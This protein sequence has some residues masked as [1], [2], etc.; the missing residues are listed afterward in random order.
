MK[1]GFI[2]RKLFLLFLSSTLVSNGLDHQTR[3]WNIISDY[4]TS[5]Q[6][7][8]LQKNFPVSIPADEVTVQLGT[9]LCPQEKQF[10]ENRLK[11]VREN[12]KKYFDI[13]QPLS[14]GFCCSGGGNRA[15]IGTLGLLSG[16]IQTNLLDVTMYL[17]GVSGSTWAIVPYFYQL[18]VLSKD[19]QT[20]CDDLYTYFLNQLSEGTRL[21]IDYCSPALLNYYEN[22]D[23]LKDLVMRYGYSQDV[24]LV[25]LWGALIGHQSL[26]FLGEN[27][28][29]QCWSMMVDQ[30]LQANA[31]LPL[32]T[33]AFRNYT[34]YAFFETSPF[35]AGSKLLGYIP[36][37]YLGSNFIN[38]K[39][40]LEGICPE[41]TLAFFLG[42]YGSSFASVVQDL[43]QME[44]SNFKQVNPL[45][46]LY[47]KSNLEKSNTYKN[48]SLFNNWNLFNIFSIKNKIKSI[49][50][51]VLQDYNFDLYAT[52]PNYNPE[53]LS[54]NEYLGLFDAGIGCN[55]PISAFTDRP[56]RFLDIMIMYDS[57]PGSADVKT[58]YEYAVNCGVAMDIQMQNLSIDDLSKE[59]MHVFNDPRSENYN[60]SSVTILYFPTQ[61]ID[62]SIPPYST[63]NFKYEINEIE[64]LK[65]LME[66]SLISNIENIRTI[67]K[68]IANKKYKGE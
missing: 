32:C 31:P 56:E 60:A 50:E 11:V 23:F 22:R 45:L 61:N 27:R 19:Y 33:A 34:D 37:Q 42:L 14:I 13:D 15:M 12:L 64:K 68:L 46:V 21:C 35:E 30:T 59:S 57:H 25:N 7:Y 41:Y 43:Y 5:Y 55:F 29:K 28:F 53:A 4:I 39:L 48:W 16:A 49:I 20:A 17:A 26:S 8:Y 58:A 40:D 47:E 10:R 36:I 51:N 1:C 65:K 62:L 18:T 24:T 66:Y 54:N 3:F 63:F 9:E 2:R 38:R 44:L 67:M 6:K 52:F